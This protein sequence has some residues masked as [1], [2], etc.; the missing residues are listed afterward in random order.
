MNSLMPSVS[1]IIPTYNCASYVGQA[2]DSVLHQ[3]FKDVEI[4]V[5][6]DGSNDDTAT[7]LEPYHAHIRYFHQA[8]QGVAIARNRGL[9]EA[10][11]ELIAFLDADDRFWSQ[12]LEQ[13]VSCFQ[14]SPDLGMVISGW[15]LVRDSGDP[16]A[17][18]EPWKGFPELNL[19]TIILNKPARPSAM[20]LRRDWCEALGGFDESLS[21]AEDLDFL[22]RLMLA[23][24]KA[25]WVPEILVDY[26]QH[27]DSLMS[28]GQQLIEDTEQVMQRFFLRSDIPHSIAILKRQ[29]RRQSYLWL[30]ARMYY[31][32]HLDEMEQCLTESLRYTS[33]RT[34]K[35]SFEWFQL[36]QGY[37][38]EYGHRFD[39][40]QLTNSSAWQHSLASLLPTGQT[41]PFSPADPF[42]PT[43]GDR[44]QHQNS[45]PP[46]HH[47]LL[48]SDDPG[49]GGILQCN[50]AIASH[51]AQ[52][53]YA[54][55]HLHFCQQTPL[56]Q[57]EQALGITQIDLHYHAGEDL[58]RTLKDIEGSKRHFLT[59]QPELIIFSDG[60]PF[61]NLAAKQA[62]I[63]LGIPYIIV[64]GFIESS[65]GHYDY[66]D[67][68][69]YRDLVAIQ[70]S[71]ARSVIAVSQEN[72][73]LLRQVFQ[74]PESIGSVIYNGRPEVFFKPQNLTTRQRLRQQLNIPQEAVVCFTSGRLEP[75]K[76]YQYQIEAIKQLKQTSS[77]W[78]QLYFV[79][80]GM[81]IEHLPKSNERE[82]KQSID[83]LGIGDRVTF[84]GQR[85]DIPDLLD[86]SDIF[87]L[88]SEAEGM[89]LSV[90]EAMAKGLPVIA[91]AV[92]GIPEELGQ[93]GQL[94][95][96]PKQYPEK[97]I[98][99]LA[100]TIERW[101]CSETRRQS[102]GEA[103]RQRAHELFRE[104]KMVS[105]YEKTVAQAL[106][107]LEDNA[108]RI[109]NV[110]PGLIRLSQQQKG[111]IQ[112]KFSYTAWIWQA[113]YQYQNKNEPLMKAALE[114]AL[115]LKPAGS[116]MPVLI[117]GEMF[118]RFCR[119]QGK[120]FNG[121]EILQLSF[122]KEILNTHS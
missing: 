40:Y 98:A 24:C 62:A 66:Q 77:A 100:E 20:M 119:E 10:K 31:D 118:S 42:P 111:D 49:A 106:K 12:K 93:T 89:P 26:R 8:N 102:L 105:N 79:W 120:D 110:A 91:S 43:S 65:C 35:T 87:I 57:R 14:G 64:L 68:V 28:Q 104:T 3:S 109:K 55:S 114:H 92:S 29:E 47:I 36:F 9:S 6:D 96:N 7:I 80:A 11:G 60:W 59:H 78:Q 71:H 38:K 76:G 56:N 54:M 103:C 52:A 1:I 117:W 122:W 97:A 82:L 39:A 23:G 37:A 18:V 51:L 5:I 30:A 75:I 69:S 13:Q 48:Y 19:E 50:H 46:Q 85:W 90:M 61:S 44:Q 107:P 70:Y 21:S 63:D 34:V 84:L 16:I 74:L 88:P 83:A 67:G 116:S 17:T 2:I 32:G 95:P 27:S 4:L 99:L 113:W 45:A 94:L 25:E 115:L 112:R 15:Q 72:L 58:T 81:G 53:G 101:T 33:E 22:L 108:I 73:T 86:M 121:Y 41:T